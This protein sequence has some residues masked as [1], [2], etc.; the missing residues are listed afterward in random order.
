MT[1]GVAAL[2][3]WGLLDRLL[4]TGC[5]SIDTYRFDFGPFVISGAPGC[6][7]LRARSTRAPTDSLAQPAAG[8][9]TQARCVQMTPPLPRQQVLQSTC[10][11]PLAAETGVL[12][13]NVA[14]IAAKAAT[15]RTRAVDFFMVS[16]PL[17]KFDFGAQEH[18]L[19]RP[20]REAVA[21]RRSLQ[22]LREAAG[23]SP[24]RARRTGS[25]DRL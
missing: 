14:A 1:P 20:F 7:T 6:E 23:G 25:R 18:T 15:M 19:A 3:R 2:R 24:H 12:S 4:S 9:Y 16:S 17:A 10:Q 5:P 8:S 21:V 11:Q 22:W 13:A